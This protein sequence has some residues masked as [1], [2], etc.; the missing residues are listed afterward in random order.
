M[1]DPTGT[2]TLPSGGAMTFANFVDM[3]D[4]LGKGND[5]SDCFASQFVQYVSGRVKLDDCDRA[6]AIAAFRSSGFKLDAL[7]AAIVKS[8][9]FVSRSN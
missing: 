8:S 6:N 5:A 9:S 3:I 4:Q 7:V 1:I 2:I